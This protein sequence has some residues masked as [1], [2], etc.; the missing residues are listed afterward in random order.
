MAVAL[1]VALSSAV[2]YA[3]AA[4]AA[5]YS[6]DLAVDAVPVANSSAAHDAEV[7]MAAPY[8][9]DHAV[10][11]VPVATSSAAHCVAA[12]LVPSHYSADFF[13]ATAF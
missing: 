13:Q 3:V 7:A 9:A 8:L 10:D 1:L 2:H 4:M 11:A 12:V 6:A 5:P